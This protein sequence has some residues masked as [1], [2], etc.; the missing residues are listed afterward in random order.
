MSTIIKLSNGIELEVYE[1]AS[2]KALQDHSIELG[3]GRPTVKVRAGDNIEVRHWPPGNL[4]LVKVGNRI[5]DIVVR[6][7]EGVDFEL[8]KNSKKTHK[9]SFDSNHN[10]FSPWM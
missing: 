3:A 8:T 4:T 5:R 10:L 9:V 2:V 6:A 1:R 7:Q